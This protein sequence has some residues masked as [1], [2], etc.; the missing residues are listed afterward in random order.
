MFVFCLQKKSLERVHLEFNEFEIA[1]KKRMA[2]ILARIEEE[3]LEVME[4]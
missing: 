3:V 2:E 4:V 1:L